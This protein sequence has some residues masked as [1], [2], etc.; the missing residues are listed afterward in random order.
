MEKQIEVS[1][2]LIA[3]CGLYCGACVKY[4]NGKC[5]G[6][7]KNQKAT[8]CKTRLCS[9]SQGYHTCA[10]CPRDVAQCETY[11]NWIAKLCSFI[12]RSNR[13]ACINRIREIEGDA[14]AREMAEKRMFS[15]K[16]K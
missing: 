13:V 10:D 2:D 9:S 7:R 14:F 12:F 11:S 1:R 15:I 5:P 4:L 8:W 16:R 6:C 3:R